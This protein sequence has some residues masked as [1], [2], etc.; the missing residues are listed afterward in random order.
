M[1][2][3]KTPGPVEATDPCCAHHTDPREPKPGPC[4]AAALH[5]LVQCVSVCCL[6]HSARPHTTHTPNSKQQPRLRRGYPLVRRTQQVPSLALLLPRTVHRPHLAAFLSGAS[7]HPSILALPRTHKHSFDL[8]LLVLHSNRESAATCRLQPRCASF[9]NRA[10]T[11][12]ATRAHRGACWTGLRPLRLSAHVCVIG[13][14][15]RR[16][17]ADDARW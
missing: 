2:C 3:L 1:S 12:P 14:V 17:A 9:L 13:I 10:R 15:S 16:I 4:P 5:H 11:L 6:G 8:T 7:P